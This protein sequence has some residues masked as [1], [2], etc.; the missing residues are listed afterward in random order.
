MRKK[1]NRLEAI[2][3]RVISDREFREEVERILSETCR[4]NQYDDTLE[5]LQDL[6]YLI[7]YLEDGVYV[8]NPD[9]TTAMVNPG[10]TTISGVRKEDFVRQ[11]VRELQKQ[12][13][14][15]ESAADLAIQ[16]KTKQTITQTYLNG[17]TGL[18]TSTPI[19][20][21]QGRVRKVVSNIR[22][23]TELTNLYRELS[24]NEKTLARYKDMISDFQSEEIGHLIF[25]SKAMETTLGYVRRAAE[26]DSN[27]LLTGESGSGKTAIAKLI[28]SMSRRSNKPFI[29][30]NCGAIPSQLFESELFGYEKGAF[31]GASPGGKIGLAEA[32][33]GGV[34]FLDE[35]SELSLDDQVK[36]LMF[37]DS[38]MVTR[39][40]GTEPRKVDV[41]VIAAGNRDLKEMV[42]NHMF[43]EDLYYRLRVVPIKIPPLRERKEDIIHI[44]RLQIDDFNEENQQEKRLTMGAFEALKNYE[45]P[46]NIRELKN[47]IEQACVFSAR[48]EIT[49]RDLPS[50]FNASRIG[51]VI[52]ATSGT[53]APLTESELPVNLKEILAE[54]EKVYLREALKKGRSVRGA[55]RLLGLDPAAVQRRKKAYRIENDT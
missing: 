15:D 9:G 53:S 16:R 50:E 24:L 37:I 3:S 17:K 26:V 12:G 49:V 55:A 21:E 25:A 42:K 46:G 47:V 39:V 22:D 40:G 7:S 28:A 23:I 30:V 29:T 4:S 48:D 13:F 41:R 32:A 33:D 1:G 44:A 11:N 52:G 19:L 38:K 31:T 5:A 54:V 14:W 18:V 2:V 27:V 43:R 20:D 35:V 45:W 6:V 8:V 10:F 51:A 34:L 36:L